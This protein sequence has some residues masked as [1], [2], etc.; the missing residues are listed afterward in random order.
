MALVAVEA[1][2]LEDVE[3]LWSPVVVYRPTTSDDERRAQ[4]TRW[5]AIVQRVEKTIPDLS[6]VSF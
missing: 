5:S 4:R 6:S 2:S 3:E 1:L